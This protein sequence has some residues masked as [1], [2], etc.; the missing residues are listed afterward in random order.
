MVTLDAVDLREVEQAIRAVPDPEIPVITID[1]LGVIRDV[2]RVRV[3]AADRAT[4][5][6]RVTITPTYSGCPAMQA[7]ADGVVEA[8]RR[9][10]IPVEVVTRLS[11]AW[12][13]DWMSESGRTKLD[14]KSVV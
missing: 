9:Y 1:E 10:G 4:D 3:D 14:R 13:T 5:G 6:L 2:E 8:G 11:P 12:T 7:M